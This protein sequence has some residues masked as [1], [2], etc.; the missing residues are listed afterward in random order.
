MNDQRIQ[1]DI[2]ADDQSTAD[3]AARGV[4]AW[5]SNNGFEDVTNNTHPTHIDRD[6]EVVA[7]I[8]AISPMMFQAEVVI[9]AGV[10]EESSVL[11]G[12]D[13]EE[14]PGDVFPEPTD[15]DDEIPRIDD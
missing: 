6:E 1:I 5:F 12:T 13:G 7:A 2:T 8:Q 4:A 14:G 15:D 9:D 10:F 3:L 11:A